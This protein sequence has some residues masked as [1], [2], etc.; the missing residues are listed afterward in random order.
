MATGNLC[1]N[2]GWP[3]NDL[4]AQGHAMPFSLVKLRINTGYG[5]VSGP[6]NLFAQGRTVPISRGSPP[7]T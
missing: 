5:K 1:L 3:R 6:V 7:I 2:T 4:I